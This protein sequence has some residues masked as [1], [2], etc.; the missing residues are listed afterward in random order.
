MK[1]ISIFIVNVREMRR[2]QKLYFKTRDYMG[3]RKAK[4]LEDIVDTLTMTEEEGIAYFVEELD[5]SE[6]IDPQRWCE[7]CKHSYEFHMDGIGICGAQANKF[8]YYCSTCKYF[9]SK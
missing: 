8:C 5:N 2:L 4:N 9:E 1:E 7:N 6:N 3:L